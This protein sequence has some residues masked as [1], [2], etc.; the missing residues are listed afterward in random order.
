[1]SSQA[2]GQVL[3]APS[4]GL[5]DRS[6]RTVAGNVL[7]G[8]AHGQPRAV[9]G[10]VAVGADADGEV[11]RRTFA[12]RHQAAE[13]SAGAMR[14]QFGLEDL[15]ALTQHP[16]GRCRR[17][18][19]VATRERRVDAHDSGAAGAFQLRLLHARVAGAQGDA[20]A[21]TAL[22]ALWSE[23]EE[24]SLQRWRGAVGAELAEQWLRQGQEARAEPML[25]ALLDEQRRR[26]G[27]Q[28]LHVGRVRLQLGRALIALG[29]HAEAAPMIQEGANQHFA[30]LGGGRSAVMRGVLE[31]T[32]RT[33]LLGGETTRARLAWQ[34]LREWLGDELGPN[35]S[36]TRLAQA[37]VGLVM[38]R[39]G[40][41]AAAEPLLREAL[42]RVSIV[43]DADAP[44]VH[45]QRM[46]LAECLLALDRPAAARELL[47]GIDADAVERVWPE[48][49]GGPWRAQLASMR[50]R[51]GGGPSTSAR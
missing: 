15:L 24:P 48:R 8:D 6:P 41:A 46:L 32:A 20:Q 7:P 23:S 34:L 35:S 50:Q 47:A 28:D 33:N 22:S 26:F 2:G 5:T 31:L 43:L 17:V 18:R 11:E 25:R 27:E 9:A 3:S 51:A 4:P 19:V 42:Q 37:H 21:T 1:M 45:Y 38:M 49:E 39:A 29:R 14:V 40:D 10:P 36:E 44:Q 12:H 13:P 16:R 30:R